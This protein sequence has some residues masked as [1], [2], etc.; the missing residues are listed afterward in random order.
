MSVLV[1][2]LHGRHI[3]LAAP[4]VNVDC[5]GTEFQPLDFIQAYVEGSYDLTPRGTITACACWMRIIIW[6]PLTDTLE[7]PDFRGKNKKDSR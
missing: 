5:F 3:G 4:P 7:N 2:Q 6:Y 1:Y